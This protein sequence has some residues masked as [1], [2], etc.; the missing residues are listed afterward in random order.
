[1]LLLEEATTDGEVH[2]HPFGAEVGEVKL[3]VIVKLLSSWGTQMGLIC[4][5]ATPHITLFPANL[6]TDTTN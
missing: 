5:L 6:T 1:M 4:A 3:S 2:E